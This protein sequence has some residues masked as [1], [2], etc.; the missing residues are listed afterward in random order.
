MSIIIMSKACSY[1]QKH[2][3][4]GVDIAASPIANTA[5]MAMKQKNKVIFQSSFAFH[6]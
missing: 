3:I 5:L 4:K 2:I 6:T 1:L